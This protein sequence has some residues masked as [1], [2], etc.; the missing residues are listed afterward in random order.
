VQ[1]PEAGSEQATEKRLVLCLDG[2]WNM[3]DSE[4]ITNIVLLRDLID[5]KFMTVSGPT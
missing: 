5:P 4:Q 2:T 3:L 1:I